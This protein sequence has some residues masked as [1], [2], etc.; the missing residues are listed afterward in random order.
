[1]NRLPLIGAGLLAFTTTAHASC[2]D[3]PATANCTEPSVEAGTTQ[4]IEPTF[5]NPSPSCKKISNACTFNL[6]VPVA[7]QQEWSSFL[8]STFI[9]AAGSCATISDCTTPTN[10]ACA[11]IYDARVI[12]YNDTFAH[13][14]R[15][16]CASPAAAMD[17]H[18]ASKAS[19][20][21]YPTQI[22]RLPTSTWTCPG[23]D[24]GTSAS[25]SCKEIGTAG[26]KVVG[27]FPG[28]ATFIFCEP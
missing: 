25:C 21:I 26:I 3:S 14:T 4:T 10:G 20:I 13:I 19:G 1:M 24:G 22:S 7:S 12:W 5:P 6:A 9:N 18:Q 28:N 8:Q 2:L 23:T 17:I 16:A 11:P 27:P 15:F